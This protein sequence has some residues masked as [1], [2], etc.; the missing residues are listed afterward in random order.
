MWH[1]IHARAHTG[2]STD[3]HHQRNINR[4]HTTS[5]ET[6]D[7]ETHDRKAQYE[8]R[9]DTDPHIQVLKTGLLTWWSSNMIWQMQIENRTTSLSTLDELEPTHL[10]TQNVIMNWRFCSTRLP[11]HQYNWPW[12][13]L[14]QTE[15]DLSYTWQMKRLLTRQSIKLSRTLP[16]PL[17]LGDSDFQ[18][19]H[20]PNSHAARPHQKRQTGWIWFRRL[21]KVCLLTCCVCFLSNI[22]FSWCCPHW[23]M[24]CL[25]A[26]SDQVRFN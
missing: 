14:L 19:G 17:C 15:I 18:S 16:E 13:Q 25:P 10:V 4:K 6:H 9:K 20:N 12:S 2:C 26:Q 5:P 21:C 22:T 24:S 7:P 3:L 11:L 1:K 8:S 23:H